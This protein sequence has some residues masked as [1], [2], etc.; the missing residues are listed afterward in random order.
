MSDTDNHITIKLRPKAEEDLENI[1]Q[2]SVNHWGYEQADKYIYELETNFR[3][4]AQY[5]HIGR[6]CS[7]ISPNLRAFYITPHIIYYK[8]ISSGIAIVRILHES[9]DMEKHI[10]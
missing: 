7:Y 2:Y 3:N 9:M 4:L 6:D 1:Y 8:L 5:R 10:R